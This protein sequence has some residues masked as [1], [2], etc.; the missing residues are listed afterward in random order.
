[1]VVGGR[2]KRVF[3]AVPDPPE[4]VAD[5]LGRWVEACAADN[6]RNGGVIVL[7]VVGA[8]QSGLT[9]VL[10][11]LLVITD[12]RLKQPMELGEAVLLGGVCFSADPLDA[13]IDQ[14]PHLFQVRL[15]PRIVEGLFERIRD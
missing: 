6:V 4:D 9:R 2:A 7:R 1:L 13:L 8:E 11:W 15:L 14:A 12:Q 3:R 10:A 5:A